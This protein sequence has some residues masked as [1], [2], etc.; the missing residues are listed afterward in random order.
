[1]LAEVRLSMREN[2]AAYDEG[3]A[4]RVPMPAVVVRATK[5]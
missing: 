1:V 2:L 3:D 5:P 4:V